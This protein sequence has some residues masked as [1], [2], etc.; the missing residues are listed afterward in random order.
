MPERPT[1]G[2]VIENTDGTIGIIQEFSVTYDGDTEDISGTGDVENS[3]VRR[4]GAPVDVGST[5]TFSGKIDEDA[6]GFSSF[7][8]A[9]KQ[10]TADTELM[11]LDGPSGDGWE[12]TGH[13]ESYEESLSRSEA[14]WNFSATFYVNSEADVTSGT[15]A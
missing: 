15:A 9:M 11:M 1:A 13:A 6:A 4:K 10:R 8:T 12:Y 14:V 3:I 5:I 2:Y 7:R